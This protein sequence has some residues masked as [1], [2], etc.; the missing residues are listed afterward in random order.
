MASTASTNNNILFMSLG[1][2]TT[3][4]RT[5]PPQYNSCP[6][7]PRRHHPA[8]VA[9]LTRIATLFSFHQYIMLLPRPPV[10]KS[11]W[12][13]IF[14]WANMTWVSRSEDGDGLEQITYSD[15]CSICL[16]LFPKKFQVFKSSTVHPV[17][18]KEK[19]DFQLKNN[20]VKVSYSLVKDR[21]K[22]R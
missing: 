8:V 19:S 9:A 20:F 4:M 10:L 13:Q 7:R 15:T 3:I 22:I 16:H 18:K 17:Q 14:T 5:Q 21:L 1:F 2:T 12:C 6:I 11:K